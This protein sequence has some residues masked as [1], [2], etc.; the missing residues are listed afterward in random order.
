MMFSENSA[1]ELNYL[2]N[3]LQSAQEEEQIKDIECKI[4]EIWME[5]GTPQTNILMEQGCEALANGDFS[6]AIRTFTTIISLNPDY[7]EA[8]NKRA[9]AYYLRGNYKSSIEDI[10]QTLDRENRHFGAL[11]GLASIYLTIGDFKGALKTYENLLKI[12]PYDQNFKKQMS[13]LRKKL[14]I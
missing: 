3:L 6:A 1:K 10:R 4:W 13:L 14:D 8:W 5:S 9:T 12:Y 2:F 11:S 7:P